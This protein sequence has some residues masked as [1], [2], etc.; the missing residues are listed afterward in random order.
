MLEKDRHQIRSNESAFKLIN[1]NSLSL[2]LS[3]MDIV[4]F[5]YPM[6][7]LNPSDVQQIQTAV[8]L[9]FDF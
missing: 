5:S 3:L 9:K 1:F 4:P 7:N 2:S 8:L 6:A